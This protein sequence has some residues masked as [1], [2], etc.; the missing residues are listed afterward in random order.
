MPELTCPNCSL[1]AEV[2]FEGCEKECECAQCGTVFPLSDEPRNSANTTER[3]SRTAKNPPASRHVQAARASWMAPLIAVFVNLTIATKPDDRT[4]TL[5]VGA[6]CGVI[7]ILGFLFGLWGIVGASRKG[8]RGTLSCYITGFR[9]LMKAGLDHHSYEYS[10]IFKVHV[11]MCKKQRA[12]YNHNLW[13]RL[14]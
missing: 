1:T 13:H 3:S 14:K 2:S 7:V 12:S 6:V 8:P 9:P 5:A 11:G 10:L 4:L